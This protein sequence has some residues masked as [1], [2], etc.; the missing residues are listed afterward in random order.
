MFLAFLWCSFRPV[1]LELLVL[2]TGL[3]PVGGTVLATPEPLLASLLA[4]PLAGQPGET[5]VGCCPWSL[6]AELEI[7]YQTWLVLS[8]VCMMIF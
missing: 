5:P 2:E 1:D 7:P 3:S 4:D 8:L 6:L